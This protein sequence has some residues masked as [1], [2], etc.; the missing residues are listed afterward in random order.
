MQDA[1]D[2]KY[3]DID[4]DNAAAEMAD[5][6]MYI[7]GVVGFNNH[8]YD[9]YTGVPVAVCTDEEIS[10]FTE[11]VHVNDDYA[12][13]CANP[14]A[15]AQ[16]QDM[17]RTDLATKWAL[18]KV[19]ANPHTYTDK[20]G[21]MRNTAQVVLITDGA[22]YGYGSPGELHYDHLSS[23]H[24]GIMGET[25]NAALQHARAIKDKG[26]YIYGVYVPFANEEEIMPALD[27]KDNRITN[28]VL[29]S[30]AI[31]AVF[32]SM[33]SSDY[34]NNNIFRFLNGSGPAE[35]TH[36]FKY[37]YEYAK[38]GNVLYDAFSSGDII[39]DDEGVINDEATGFGRFS[40]FDDSYTE[41]AGR[42]N[43]MVQRID[44]VAIAAANERGYA[45]R[46]SEI[47]DEVTAPFRIADSDRDG[48]EDV[49]VYAVP[50][51]PAGLG[52]DNI[53]ADMDASTH[54]VAAFR[55]GEESEWVALNGPGV[56]N[57]KLT[58]EINGNT[59]RVTGWDYEANSV[60][61]IDKDFGLGGT[62]P[63]VYHPGDYGYKLVVVIL[64]PMKGQFKDISAPIM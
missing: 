60:C 17:T 55:W 10:A 23:T 56:T 27:P 20:N 37:E 15:D 22:P 51:I 6:L 52:I 46:E 48:T 13:W 29:P 31:S 7:S 2:G 49:R 41:L 59:V 12:A 14:D 40:W 47:V 8:T 42:V 19:L 16:I 44:G 33:Y 28:I 18:E 61:D 36:Q 53:P 38:G 64:L 50:R 21:R 35:A 30:G 54:E 1:E 11:I 5:H 62:N 58:V 34:P 4:P 25:T 45:G 39:Y 9:K 24:T 26:A 32:L 57:N 43:T 63:G 3:A